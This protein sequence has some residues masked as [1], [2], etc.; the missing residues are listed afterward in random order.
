MDDGIHPMQR[1]TGVAGTAGP[2]RDLDDADWD[3]AIARARAVGLVITRPDPKEVQAMSDAIDALHATITED[4]W[5][6]I[7]KALRERGV[8]DFYL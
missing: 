6:R 5:V 2:R 4:E 8:E 7:E 1:A 3:H